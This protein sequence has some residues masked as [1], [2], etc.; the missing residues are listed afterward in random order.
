MPAK[1]FGDTDSFIGHSS[2]GKKTSFVGKWKDD[3]DENGQHSLTC[4]LH[5]R[6]RPFAIWVHGFPKVIIKKD[7]DEESRFVVFGKYNCHEEED[8]LKEQFKTDKTTGDRLVPPKVCGF[9]K[10]IE[11]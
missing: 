6:A 10:F 11:W 5:M 1:Q 4:W 2:R 7:N 8:V 3:T 9:C